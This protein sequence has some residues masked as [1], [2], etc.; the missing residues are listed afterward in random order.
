MN[1][2]GAALPSPFSGEMIAGAARDRTA[3]PA[4]T[5]TSEEARRVAEEFEAMALA[6]LLQPIFA[7]I[8]PRGLGGGG[9]GEEMFRPMLVQEYAAAMAKG[10]GVGLADAVMRELT[11]LQAAAP[12]QG[13]P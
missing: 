1:I 7:Q 2:G 13:D 10:G 4:S 9:A 11:R 5:Q 8:N 3:P 6:E 12:S